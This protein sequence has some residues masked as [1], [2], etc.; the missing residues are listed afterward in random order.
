MTTAETKRG[1]SM[2]QKIVPSLWFDNQAEEAAKLYTSLFKNSRIK[3][4]LRYSEAG[5]D[6]HR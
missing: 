2:E 1:E 3:E 6:I 4:S 5:R